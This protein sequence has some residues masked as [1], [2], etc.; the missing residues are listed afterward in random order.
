MIPSSPRLRERGVPESTAQVAWLDAVLSPNPAKR[1]TERF[2]L[3]YTPVWGGVSAVVM[4]GGFAE[5]WGDVELMLFGVILALGALIGPF[6]VRPAEERSVRLIDTTAFKMGLSVVLFAFGLNYSE[7]PYFWEVLHMHY[8]FWATWTIDSNP[9]FLYFLTIA[10]FATYSVLICMAFRAVRALLSGA[11]RWARI[12]AY[13]IAP[14]GVAFLETLLNANPWTTRIFCYDDM[15]LMLW[16]G[17]FSYGIAFVF[18]LP[19]WLNLDERPGRPVSAFT[20]V[21]WVAAAIYADLLTLDLLRF[22]IAPQVTLIHPG[23]RGL[24]DFGEGCLATPVKGTP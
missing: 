5:R 10:Y 8:G 18:A 1:A 15:G 3:L 17:T 12:P 4:L 6:L 2:W 23:A 9:I 13:A 19:V 24:G 7:T 11:P 21:V 14:F 22:T 20:L 16:F